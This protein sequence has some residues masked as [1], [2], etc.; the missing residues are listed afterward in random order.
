[1]DNKTRSI[2]ISKAKTIS[3]QIGYPKELID[4]ASLNEYYGNLEM[5]TNN[6]LTNYLRLEIF[7]YDTLFGSLRQPVIRTSWETLLNLDP[8]DVNA[9]YDP[10]E[11]SMRNVTQISISEIFCL[12]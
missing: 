4:N 7:N 1:M 11:N 8:T 9:F 2:A 6:L 10:Y 12:V 5:E 3:A